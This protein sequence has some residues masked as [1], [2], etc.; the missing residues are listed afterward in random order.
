MPLTGKNKM[1]ECPACGERIA[2][3]RRKVPHP[4]TEKC[5][6]NQIHRAFEKRG[7]IQ[8]D[9][10]RAKIMK[11]MGI[12]TEDAM[13]GIH[14]E[15]ER[16]EGEKTSRG[17]PKYKLIDRR[18]M[19]TFAPKGAMRVLLALSN[20]P[21]VNKLFRRRAVAALWDGDEHILKA[22]D[23]VKRLDGNVRS[24]IWKLVVEAEEAKAAKKALEQTQGTGT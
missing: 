5:K 15:E 22:I 9:Q 16:I 10:T 24:Y 3:E 23:T 7:W 2:A 14:Q 8:V 4:E 13:G 1:T 20:M 21:S 6:A 12:P 18:H 17:F 19:V 11:E